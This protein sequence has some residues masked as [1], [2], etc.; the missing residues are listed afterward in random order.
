MVDV[1][2]D[3]EIPNVFHGFNYNPIPGKEEAHP[4]RDAYTGCSL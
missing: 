4:L 2:D 1:R 3:A